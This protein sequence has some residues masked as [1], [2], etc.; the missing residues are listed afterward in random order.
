MS[1]WGKSDENPAPGL[2]YLSVNIENPRWRWL[3]VLSLPRTLGVHPGSGG[4]HGLGPFGPMWFMT[5]KEGKDYRSLKAGD[6]VFSISLER[7]LEPL[8][9]PKKSRGASKS[10]Q[11]LRVGLTQLMESQ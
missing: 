3:L 4:I 5:R 1:R 11:A 2:P 8:A 7:A 10:K 6:D 9:E